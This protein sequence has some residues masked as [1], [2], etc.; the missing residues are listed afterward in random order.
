MFSAWVPYTSEGKTAIANYPVIV[1]E[2]KLALQDCARELNKFLKKKY[3]HEKKKRRVLLFKKYS[4]MISRALSKLTD[5][6]EE[7]IS[8]EMEK[9]L[10]KRYGGLN[11]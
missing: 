8:S 3:S 11:E 5:T 9:I 6:K 1:K 2:I 4:S 10:K 7:K